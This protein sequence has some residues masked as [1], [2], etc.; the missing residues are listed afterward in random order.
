MANSPH[1][2]HTQSPSTEEMISGA[3][4]R[5]RIVS[6]LNTNSGKEFN[7]NGIAEG[8]KEPSKYNDIGVVLTALANA[9]QIRMRKDGPKNWYFVGNIS[10]APPEQT[11]TPPVKKIANVAPN[12]PAVELSV[13]GM[14]IAI[15][16][17]TT[18]P[19][20]K[21]IANVAPNAPAVELSVGGMAIA[22]QRDPT[23]GHIRIQIEQ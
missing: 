8:I 11:G 21:K 15:Q 13:G 20:V 17:Q 5:A 18:T 19:P 14:A 23:T 12:A 9:G 1:R 6:F 2:D 3:D 22:I 16:E 10:K 4:R 7:R